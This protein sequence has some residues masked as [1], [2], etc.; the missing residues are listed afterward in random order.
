MPL[1]KPGL[2]DKIVALLEALYTNPDNLTTEEA[3]DKYATDLSD[4]IDAFVRTGLVETT[5]TASAQTGSI[6]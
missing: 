2:K 4:A 3:R 1:D 6:T 5:G